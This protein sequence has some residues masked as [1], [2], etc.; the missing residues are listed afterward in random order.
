M[1]ATAALSLLGKAIPITKM[2]GQVVTRE[3]GLR[4]FLTIHPSYIL[5]IREPADKEAERARFL[6]DMLAVRK[7]MAA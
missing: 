4:V 7:L 2:R 5:R 3:D 1:G 6:D